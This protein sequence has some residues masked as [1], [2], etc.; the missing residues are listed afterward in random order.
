MGWIGFTSEGGYETATALLAGNVMMPRSRRLGI[1]VLPPNGGREMGRWRGGS[2]H[3]R[4]GTTCRLFCGI[5]YMGA[6][7]QWQRQPLKR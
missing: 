4:Q 3:E 6:R 2:R 7:K 5:M 1:A